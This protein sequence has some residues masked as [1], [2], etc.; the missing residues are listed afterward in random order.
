MIVD[1]VRRLPIE[2]VGPRL[3]GPF[4]WGPMGI[5]TSMRSGRAKLAVNPA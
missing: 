1:A 5:Q 4:A 2:R 3:R